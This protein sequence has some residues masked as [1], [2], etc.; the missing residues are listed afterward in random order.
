MRKQRLAKIIYAVIISYI[1]VLSVGY[2]LFSDSLTIKGVA[3]TVDYYSAT[4][5]PVSTVAI[6]ADEDDEI[7]T[8]HDTE[9]L[10]NWLSF[11]SEK[12]EEG[13]YEINYVKNS[14]IST[15]S[16]ETTEMTISFSFT[17]P[18]VLDYTEGKTIVEI[19][20]NESNIISD[21]TAELS[22]DIIKSG[23][24]VVV[25]LKVKIK[26]VQGN[27]N[28]QIKTTISY[29]FQ[30]KLRTLFVVLNYKV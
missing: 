21:A 2:A 25:T 20:E 12:W 29:V 15:A 28:E 19:L 11:D 5:L 1:M 26:P 30:G 7:T 22:S 9:N 24:G 18:T 3:S 14:N 16:S 23:E 10:P 8:Y 13:T 17:N 27:T 6:L 4:M